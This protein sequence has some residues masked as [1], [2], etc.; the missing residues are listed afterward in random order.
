MGSYSIS[1]SAKSFASH[2]KSHRS[3]WSHHRTS[4][5]NSLSRRSS[6]QQ[7]KFRIRRQKASTALQFVKRQETY[8]DYDIIKILY[9]SL[10][11]SNLK[12]ASAIW[13]PHHREA[14]ER[15]GECSETVRYAHKRRFHF[16]ARTTKL[17]SLPIHRQM[18]RTREEELSLLF[19]NLSYN[20]GL[21]VI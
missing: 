11:R 1:R 16:T 18:L 17:H 10:V 4:E 20:L 2:I 8:F 5:R 14:Q 3:N 19:I 21:R 15:I 7:Q 6:G 13:S 12:F 9:S